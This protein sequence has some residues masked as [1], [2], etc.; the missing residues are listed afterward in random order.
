MLIKQFKYSNEFTIK[1]MKNVLNTRALNY[2]YL[3]HEMQ[4]KDIFKVLYY[5]LR[6]KI[7]VQI[8][9]KNSIQVQIK[10]SNV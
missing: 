2:Q 6:Y 3:M 7:Q 1:F 10:F 9:H 4:C 8:K 5:S